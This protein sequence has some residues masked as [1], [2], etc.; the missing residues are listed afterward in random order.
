MGV[1]KE[2]QLLSF[3]KAID[4]TL[5]TADPDE[6]GRRACPT[7]PERAQLH[8]RGP[9]WL[10]PVLPTQ[11]HVTRAHTGDFSI[12]EMGCRDRQSSKSDSESSRKD[13]AALQPNKRSH[14]ATEPG[15]GDTRVSTT[16]GAHR[17]SLPLSHQPTE[18][19]PCQLNSP[20]VPACSCEAWGEAGTPPREPPGEHTGAPGSCG[21]PRTQ[22]PSGSSC[23][24]LLRGPSSVEGSSSASPL[25]LWLHPRFSAL[26]FS[27]P[28]PQ[29][30]QASHK[31]IIFCDEKAVYWMY[32]DLFSFLTPKLTAGV[33]PNC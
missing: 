20:G 15:G 5:K 12:E 17:Q 13:P 4:N 24:E 23:G 21:Q 26:G 18:Q 1:N 32:G 7:G 25:R 14:G 3:L 29:T 6:E 11:T 27:S 16:D 19:L 9:S 8:R 30:P 22:A 28:L 2:T 10:Q 33:S 31:R